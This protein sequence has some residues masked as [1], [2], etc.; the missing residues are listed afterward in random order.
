[1]PPTSLT[2]KIC[3]ILDNFS[4]YHWDDFCDKSKCFDYGDFVSARD[5]EDTIGVDVGIVPTLMDHIPMRNY[6]DSNDI[7][8]RFCDLK[9]LIVIC[10]LKCPCLLLSV[11]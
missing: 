9:Y 6:G 11:G 7:W 10:I 2:T 3:G 5:I 8:L 1:M 4:I